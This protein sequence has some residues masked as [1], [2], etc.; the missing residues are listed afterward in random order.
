MPLLDHFHPPLAPQRHWHSFHNAWAAA[1]AADLNL[2]L[3]RGY[4]AE[5]N[6]QFNIEIDIASMSSS[7][8]VWPGKY[9]PTKL[10]QPAAPTQTIPFAVTTDEIEILIF[11]TRA[12][13]TLAG[14]IELVSPSN[15]DRPE[16]RDDF[17]SKCQTYLKMGIGLL[18]VDIVTKR[19]ADLH[20]ELIVRLNRDD[21]RDS[22]QSLSTT[23]YR[24]GASQLEI[25]REPLALGGQLPTMPLWLKTGACLAVDLEMTYQKVRVDYKLDEVEEVD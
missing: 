21:A 18:V 5:A 9:E 8:A 23:S 11:E 13:A 16:S 2:Q 14:V 3:P 20:A 1:I 4:F 6:V 15:K 12:G 25:W 17:S 24:P 7:N 19:W 10:W 22:D